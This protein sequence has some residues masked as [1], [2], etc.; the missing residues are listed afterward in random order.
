VLATSRTMDINKCKSKVKSQKAK[1]KSVS[2]TGLCAQAQQRN[3]FD[4]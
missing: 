2:G 3:T 1:V 4:F